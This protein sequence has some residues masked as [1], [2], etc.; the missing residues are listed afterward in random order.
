MDLWKFSNMF[1]PKS[2][3]DS[4]Y[5][6]SLVEKI[7]MGTQ[8]EALPL[9]VQAALSIRDFLD[10][11]KVKEILKPELEKILNVYLTLIKEIDNEELVAAL[12]TLMTKY[13]DDIHKYAIQVSTYLVEQ[14]KRLVKTDVEDDDGEAAL[15]AVGCVTSIRRLLDSVKKQSDLIVQ[16][17]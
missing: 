13:Q 14:Y 3:Q 4:I 1:K 16:I 6:Q 2:D 7:F 9:R 12:E 8:D 11:S 10:I 15:A 17:Q 5:L